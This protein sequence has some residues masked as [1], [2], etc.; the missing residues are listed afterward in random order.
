MSRTIRVIIFLIGL[1]GIGSAYLYQD[2]DFLFLLTGTDFHRFLHF[3]AKKVFRLLLNDFSMLLI[4]YALFSSRNTMVLAL[5]V[6]AI[7]LFILLPVYLLVKLSIE[8][9]SEIS[10]PILSQFHR[11]IVNPT[12]MILL[13]PA[14]YFQERARR[15][16]D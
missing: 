6:Q 1:L 12:L 4:I 3:A 7:D 8:G 15:D 16:G 11:L 2:I 14:I 9:D 5:F 10:M 13:I